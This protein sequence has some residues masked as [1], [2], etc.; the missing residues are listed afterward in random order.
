MYPERVDRLKTIASA[1]SLI[2]LVLNP[3]PSRT[4]QHFRLLSRI[5]D[6]NPKFKKHKLSKEV[7]N[8]MYLNNEC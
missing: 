4:K 7:E 1:P 8:R 3:L 5:C 2:V 6:G